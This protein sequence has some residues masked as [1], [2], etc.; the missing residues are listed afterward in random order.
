MQPSSHPM[1]LTFDTKVSLTV[2]NGFLPAAGTLLC[3]P[4]VKVSEVT[5]RT[6]SNQ[7]GASAVAGGATGGSSVTMTQEEQ[8]GLGATK[9][10]I[11]TAHPNFDETM[12]F[13]CPS[14]DRRD[15]TARRAS[16]IAAGVGPQAGSGEHDPHAASSLVSTERF[17]VIHI[18]DSTGNFLGFAQ[19]PFSLNR[20]SSGSKRLMLVPRFLDERDHP[21]RIEDMKALD[22][23]GIDD[24]GFMDIQ[25]TTTMIPIGGAIINPGPVPLRTPL[26]PPPLPVGLVVKA[27][28]IP[29]SAAGASV[30]GGHSVTGSRSAANGP[31]SFQLF[32]AFD[33][34]D[35]TA[36]GPSSASTFRLENGAP[37]FIG[38][39]KVEFLEAATFLCRAQK[40]QHGSTVTS[41]VVLPI[42]PFLPEAM[43]RDV[44]YCAPL[45]ADGVDE[46]QGI[47]IV[48]IRALAKPIEGPLPVC[49]EPGSG[50]PRV[51]DPKHQATAAHPNQL[52]WGRPMPDCPAG[53]Y[54][55]IAWESENHIA[56]STERRWKRD[57]IRHSRPTS[58]H[59]RHIFESLLGRVPLDLNIAQLA[60]SFFNKAANTLTNSELQQLLPAVLFHA[61]GL[62]LQDAVR[63][64]FVMMRRDT[65]RAIKVADVI[66]ALEHSLFGRTVDMPSAEI[67]RRVTD[68]LGPK[69]TTSD[70][71]VGGGGA[72]PPQPQARYVSFDEFNAFIV[73][74]GALW[75]D[76]GASLMFSVTDDRWEQTALAGGAGAASQQQTVLAA[77]LNPT[78]NASTAP[79][80][81]PSAGDTSGTLQ[82]GNAPTAASPTATTTESPENWRTFTIRVI[83]TGRAFS[84]TSHVNDTID[85]VMQMVEES[86]TIPA[87][88]QK[89]IFHGLQVDSRRKIGEMFAATSAL[90]QASTKQPEVSLQEKEEMLKLT[91]VYRDKNKKWEQ[92]FLATEKVLR[93]RAFVQHKTMIPLSRCV[94][95]SCGAAMQDR[96]CL[97]HYKLV[98]GS[99]I[100]VFQQ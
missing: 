77:Q 65:E 35:P 51:N 17:L 81:K 58:E 97:D 30:M 63:F 48:S 5:R 42:Q 54:Q 70:S 96:H 75:Y 44:S 22:R 68:I 74:H 88:R 60:S 82:H 9:Q 99:I 41:T 98:D 8:R 76:L 66:F 7:R 45:Y 72:H 56:R 15:G 53:A 16:E 26:P 11:F 34:N 47:L 64:A 36:G 32:V 23:L 83:K 33:G 93:L 14:L 37:L 78:A 69:T 85:D 39:S 18:E 79:A 67:E 31:V 89:W 29:S 92:E 25:W 24:F 95:T 90:A 55:P 87:S 40:G 6:Y 57:C 52:D 27:K 2:L 13:V 59:V 71:S 73:Q 86:S 91:I 84:V 20:P 100:E 21:T 28:W 49:R 1:F 10:R 94:M 46:Q 61:E 38:L 19:C 80:W 3:D 50:C 43:E 4:I 12:I 62:S